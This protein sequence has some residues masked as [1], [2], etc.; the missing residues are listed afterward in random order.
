M[1]IS[2]TQLW[3]PYIC[4][5]SPAAA[6]RVHACRNARV[7]Q[8]AWSF[9]RRSSWS[10]PASVEA[11]RLCPHHRWAQQRLFG[12]LCTFSAPGIA[13]FQTSYE[14]LLE[15]P[16]MEQ[17]RLPRG[18]GHDYLRLTRLACSS[19]RWACSPV[20]SLSR[21]KGRPAAPSSPSAPCRTMHTGS[22]ASLR[23]LFTAS[24]LHLVTPALAGSGASGGREGLEG[25]ASSRG[26]GSS[27][28][29][30]GRPEARLRIRPPFQVWQPAAAVTGGLQAG[31]PG[32]AKGGP[33]RNLT[34]TATFACLAGLCGTIRRWCLAYLA[35]KRGRAFHGAEMR[36]ETWQRP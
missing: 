28:P 31:C 5:V 23:S 10:L 18:T 16:M 4:S 9:R 33:S 26:R 25:Q 30:A 11:G 21:S 7:C 19:W 6:K 8:R 15:L 17:A 13:F 12:P 29:R 35:L 14:Y 22:A 27:G 1:A 32:T 36:A 34:G 2:C 20:W 3:W 24:L